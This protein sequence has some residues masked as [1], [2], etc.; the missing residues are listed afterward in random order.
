[1]ISCFVHILCLLGEPDFVKHATLQKFKNTK[2]AINYV[3][4]EKS[5]TPPTQICLSSQH[6]MNSGRK[7]VC[8]GLSWEFILAEGFPLSREVIGSSIPHNFLLISSY[9]LSR[10]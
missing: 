10:N 9:V 5:H 8:L 4:L 2:Y 7:T 3:L 1:M 6:N